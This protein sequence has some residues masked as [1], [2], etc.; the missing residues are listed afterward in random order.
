MSLQIL[1]I[2]LSTSRNSSFRK[3]YLISYQSSPPLNAEYKWQLE[4]KTIIAME[5]PLTPNAQSSLEL[6]Q[7]VVERITYYLTDI[8]NRARL[9]RSA[10]QSALHE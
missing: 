6:L 4:D 7:G 1:W 2:T 3:R 5:K 8:F 10:A 9:H